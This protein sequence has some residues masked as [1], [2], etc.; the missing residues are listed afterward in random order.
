M[1][2]KHFLNNLTVPSPCP[3][4]WSSMT[5]NDQVRFCDHCNLNVHNLSQMTRTQAQRLI[6]RSN[7]RLCVRYHHD[8]TGQPRTLAVSQTLHRIGRRT[9]QLAAGAFTA[10]L[11]ITSAVAESSA[12]YR[13]E[14]SKV[15][16]ATQPYRV[17][18]LDSVIVGTIKDPNGAVITGASISVTNEQSGVVLYT[19]SDFNGEFRIGNL[20]TGVYKARIEAPGFT[21]EEVDGIYVKPSSETRIDRSL[22][23]A[24]LEETVEVEGAAQTD[25]VMSGMVAFVSPEDPFVKAAQE[26]NLE[27]LTNL[28]AGRDVNLRDKRSGTTALEHAVRNANREMVQLLLSA[29]ATVNLTNATGETVL[30]MLDADATSDLVWDLINAGAKVNLK[31][32]GDNT[33]LMQAAGAN[34][35]EALKA[36]LDAGAEVEAKNKHGQT[37][38]MLAASEGSVNAVRA[39]VLA[40]ANLNARDEDNKDALAHAGQNDHAA[41]VRFLKSQ[42][43]FEIVAEEVEKAP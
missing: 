38:L 17:W 15:P 20:E 24:A 13:A 37:A 19:S 8:A 23:I 3:A 42:G 14:N 5:G 30:M 25:N 33:A 9:S 4:D 40:G 11:S 41:V 6:S 29:G 36:L 28:I 21:V 35:L 26:D 27:A 1:A 10:T 32:E 39:L 2:S 22:S 7:G 34:N 43:A 18:D 16:D 31:D 12:N